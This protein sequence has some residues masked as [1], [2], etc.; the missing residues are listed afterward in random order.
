[1][2]LVLI[3]ISI[4][5]VYVTSTFQQLFL[6]RSWEVRALV[7]ST[8]NVL[9]EVTGL[10]K[11]F[12]VRLA[13]HIYYGHVL[14]TISLVDKGQIHCL[15]R[16]FVD[17]R[18]WQRKIVRLAF[19]Y[20]TGW[21]VSGSRLQLQLSQ[22]LNRDVSWLYRGCANFPMCHNLNHYVLSGLAHHSTAAVLISRF[23]FPYSL[24]VLWRD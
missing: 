23:K 14:S 2:P 16:G 15:F 7:T 18:C 8:D 22:V 13:H 6:G 9:A 12:L 17:D 19:R 20:P 24:R 5:F 10:H 21:L 3:S 11:K 1:M 4:R